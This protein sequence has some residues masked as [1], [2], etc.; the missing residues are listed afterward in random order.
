MPEIQLC[1]WGCGR[2]HASEKEVLGCKLLHA[3]DNTDQIARL[4]YENS[5]ANWVMKPW[6]D[7]DLEQ[8]HNFIVKA[9]KIMAFA[10]RYRCPVSKLIKLIINKG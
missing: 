4:L 9:K 10:K 3:Q 1:C 6:Y 5:S 2:T 8:G 7:L